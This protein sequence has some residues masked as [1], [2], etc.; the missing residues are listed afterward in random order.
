MI[1]DVRAIGK[2]TAPTASVS[3]ADPYFPFIDAFGQYRHKDWPGKVKS[4]ED[5]ASRRDQETRELSSSPG[6]KDWDKYGGSASGPQLKA[7]GFFR[8]EKVRAKWWLVDPEG[9][10]FSLT[11]SI[12]SGP[13]TA[14]RLRNASSGLRT[15]LASSRNLLPS[16]PTISLSK[17]IMPVDR[18]SASPS[19]AR[20][21]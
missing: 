14:H 18:P 10:L 16:F 9:H 12:V 5:L 11:V 6:P 2:Y 4:V 1:S 7:T 17:D 15:F 20:T 19:S 21:C 3:D 8:T 13:S